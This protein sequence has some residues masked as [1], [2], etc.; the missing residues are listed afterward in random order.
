[1]EI[2]LTADVFIFNKAIFLVDGS[3]A[4]I[5]AFGKILLKHNDED[6]M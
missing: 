4:M 5:D 2:F 6:P 3:I 1:M